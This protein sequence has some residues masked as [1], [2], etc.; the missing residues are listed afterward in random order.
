M[1]YLHQI[2]VIFHKLI[3]CYTI[4]QGKFST[5]R[6]QGSQK[7]II[8]HSIGISGMLYEH[9]WGYCVR[10]SYYNHIYHI[11]KICYALET[12]HSAGT[13]EITNQILTEITTANLSWALIHKHIIKYK[14]TSCVRCMYIHGTHTWHMIAQ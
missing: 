3:T 14:P 6:Q 9:S 2:K 4:K 10:R 1:T 13:T 5:K 7:I 11:R 12:A 8:H